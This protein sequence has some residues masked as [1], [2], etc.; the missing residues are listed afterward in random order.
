M[1]RNK[2]EQARLR[3]EAAEQG[4]E[5]PPEE[6]AGK[7]RKRGSTRG[8]PGGLQKL[9]KLDARARSITPFPGWKSIA[10]LSKLPLITGH[11]MK[12][13]VQM[14][15]FMLDGLIGY[16]PKETEADRLECEAVCYFIQKYNE[17]YLALTDTEFTAK[18]MV[19][20]GKLLCNVADLYEKCPLRQ[21][22]LVDLGTRKFHIVFNHS[23]DTIRM[24]GS[25]IATNTSLWESYHRVL[26]HTAR[27]NM[28]ATN[29]WICEKTA[30]KQK[31]GS[32]YI[33]VQTKKIKEIEIS[34]VEH[35]TT[36]AGEC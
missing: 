3:L 19:K 29:E 13:I 5:L 31:M 1:I 35:K 21:Y 25:L 12:L 15:D 23:I 4:F 24:Y 2:V 17:L 10:E 16:G 30:L 33:G 8:R 18:T 7:K 32:I 26:K 22:S 9:E 6:N 11:E 34:H 28:N 14:L 36:F 20:L 27:R